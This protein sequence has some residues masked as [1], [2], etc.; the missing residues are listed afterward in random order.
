VTADSNSRTYRPHRRLGAMSFIVSMGIVSLFSDAAYEGARSILGAYMAELGATS[1]AVG[2]IAGGGELLGY[3]VRMIA[4]PVADKTRKFWLVTGVG[5][6]VNLVSIPTMG[7]VRQWPPLAGLVFAERTGKAVRTPARDAML[8]YAT[9]GV[10]PGWGFGIHEALDQIGA[11]AGPLGLA[12]VI[13]LGVGYSGGFVWLSIP[14]GLALLTLLVARILFPRPE[15]LESSSGEGKGNDPGIDGGLEDAGVDTGI[16][17]SSRHAGTITRPVST[18]SRYDGEVDDKGNLGTLLRGDFALFIA[19][20]AFA[21]AGLADFALVAFHAEFRGIVSSATIP[22][23]FA[24]A[25][26]IDGVSALGFG[27]LFDRIGIGA[28][29]LA[30]LVSAPFSAAAFS[31]SPGWLLVGAALWAIGLGAQESIMR[32]AV[33]V[34]VPSQMRGSAYGIL[35][36]I[37]GISWFLGSAAMGVLYQTSRVALVAFS[38]TCEFIAAVI[39][40]TL[41]MRRRLHEAGQ[42]GAG[43]DD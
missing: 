28:L 4:G 18:R 9:E 26:G 27:R 16:D 12:L 10:G 21:G 43:V 40:L 36:G 32:S 13:S 39:L 6:F 35:G 30:V 8:S 19:G 5:Y 3:L 11:V 25:M 7:L 22:L 33:V 1:A 20:V 41:W 42:S 23:V 14:V 2:L 34:L 24:I 17:T 29:S 37:F 15:A 38:V 31:S